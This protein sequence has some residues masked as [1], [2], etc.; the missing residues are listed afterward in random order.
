MAQATENSADRVAITRLLQVQPEWQGM[1]IAATSVRLEPFTLL[2][3][4]PPIAETKAICKPLYHSA[5]L[6]ALYEGWA[7]TYEE[8]GQLI[9][10]GQ[11]KLLPA[12]DKQVVVPLAA[13]VSPSM[14]LQVV[15]DRN[16]QNRVAY[17]PLNGGS[18]LGLRFGTTTSAL[19]DHLKWLN[20]ML[21]PSLSRV[22]AEPIPLLPLADRGLQSGEECHSKTIKGTQA[23]LTV[24]LPRLERQDVE[25]A[26]IAFLQ[27]ASSFFLNLWM[28]ACKCMLLAA[29]GIVGSSLVTA[30]AGNGYEF[31]LQLAGLPGEWIAVSDQP[32]QG[33]VGQPHGSETSC[34]A[35]GDSAVVDALGFGGMALGYAPALAAELQAFIPASALRLS[36]LLLHSEH[37]GFSPP[38]PRVG[39]TARK[40]IETGHAPLVNLGILDRDGQEGLIGRGVYIPPLELFAL[41]C[42]QLDVYLSR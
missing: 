14:Q 27:T 36:S 7:Q 35:I 11:I 39:L 40:V 21:A 19:I 15:R 1:A 24:L 42:R 34:G 25:P 8:A 5:T 37:P 32:P 18:Q 28:A 33:L 4:G 23:L 22:L 30:M 29:V 10:S 38:L 20:G 16:D 9:R 6:A 12:Q 31:G 2:H 41:A 3:A 17:S 26:A 13:V